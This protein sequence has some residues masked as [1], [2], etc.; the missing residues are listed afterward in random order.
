MKSRLEPI[1]GAWNSFIVEFPS[2][3]R[4]RRG[5]QEALQKI[6]FLCAAPEKNPAELCFAFFGPQILLHPVV[7][8]DVADRTEGARLIF[9]YAAEIPADFKASL[10]LIQERYNAPVLVAQRSNVQKSAQHV[11]EFLQGAATRGRPAPAHHAAGHETALGVTLEAGLAPLPADV[12]LW[13]GALPQVVLEHGG[14]HGETVTATVEIQDYRAEYA[15]RYVLQNY[16]ENINRDRM[17]EMVSLSPG[18]FSNL[19]RVETGM[20]FSDYLIQ[21]RIDNAKRLL[22]RFDL[23]VEEVSKECGF[24]SLAHFSRTFKDR[25]GVPPLKYRKT[26]NHE[27]PNHEAPAGDPA[28]LKVMG[29]AN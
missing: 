26:P 15:C 6:L 8:G 7:S 20:S 17:A 18:Y 22:R 4:Q 28:D 14:E 5:D 9:V 12:A 16:K 2:Y 21:I 24:N 10:E 19:F 25:C 11:L 1:E 29:Q 13:D 23:S 3:P 27:A